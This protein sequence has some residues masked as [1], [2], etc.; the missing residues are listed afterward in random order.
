[1]R[2]M[3]RLSAIAGVLLAA[4]IPANAASLNT[5]NEVGAA[6]QACWTPPANSGNASVTLS[7]SFKR[8]G[9]LIG[10]PKPTAI[11]VSGDDKARQAY[12]DAATAALR[13]CL[14]LSFS[15]ALAQGIA[16]NV[17]T[18]QFNSPKQ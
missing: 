6:L 16:G 11:K 9:T 7:F 4:P 12:V 2:S 10:P 13:N 5:M 15:P 8:D 14:P 1:M 17:F 18:L 3:A